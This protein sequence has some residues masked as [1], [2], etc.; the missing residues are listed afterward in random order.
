MEIDQ[1]IAMMLICI[2]SLLVGTQG[3]SETKY[4]IT[5]ITQSH[6]ERKAQENTTVN[7]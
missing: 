5:K 6:Y 2:G 3:Y 4:R 7:Y 1:I